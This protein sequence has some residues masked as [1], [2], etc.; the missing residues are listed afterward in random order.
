MS[1]FYK[2]KIVDIKRETK[3]SVSIA[4]GI[5]DS[6]KTEFNFVAGQYSTLKAVINNKEVRR[7]YSICTSPNSQEI[8]VVVKEVTNGTFSVYANRNLK[9]GDVL[10]V[11]KPE[12]KFILPT[13]TANTKNYLGFAA[14]S[15]ITPIM[16]MIQ[17]VLNNEPNSN[18]VL[19]Y[20][21]KS[22]FET[23]FYD[24][25][26]Q[27]K[28]E[29]PNRFFVQYVFSKEQPEGSLFGRI[30][31]SVVNYVLNTYKNLTFNDAYICGPEMM[32]NTVSDTLNLK[33]LAKENIHF[34][35]F[36][37]SE[38]KTETKNLNGTAKITIMLDDE[39]VSLEMDKKETI[40]DVALK[41]QLDAPYSC[42][43]GVCS[44]CIAK[45]TQGEASMDKNTILSKEEVAE[46]LILTCQAH[47]VSDTIVIDFDD[48]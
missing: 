48:V 33:G 5:P 47:P 26:N 14:G 11:S 23:I 7:A 42:Q 17:A 2:L 40:L 46:G 27:L 12:G 39:E 15:G 13:N 31:Q 43:G 16:A 20:G 9:N 19:V 36:T 10:E 8:R 30:D 34:E 32:I 37:A 29:H 4:F 21:N 25:I 18:F 41:N 24:K 22:T 45:V 6:L 28:Q 44:S 1:K 3:D 35:L 38:S